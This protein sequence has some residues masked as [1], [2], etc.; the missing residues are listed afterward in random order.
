VTWQFLPGPRDTPSNA[1]GLLDTGFLLHEA[2]RRTVQDYWHIINT[3]QGGSFSPTN[4]T[5]ATQLD[6]LASFVNY[7]LPIPVP[8][9]TDPSLVAS[10]R[11]AFE[12]AGCEVCHAGPALTDSG[13]GNPTLDLAAPV[14]Q[15]WSPGDPPGVL[16]HDVGTCSTASYPD[17]A[18]TD[19]DSDARPACLFD[20]PALRGLADSAPYFHDGSAATLRDTLEMT[21]GKMGNIN[22]LS[23]DEEN[24]LIEYLRSL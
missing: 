18:G 8:P 7:A 23:A 9:Q 20:T 14:V 10:G 13:T 21:R 16:L 19:D 1:G 17:V 5:Q 2:G 6:A 12:K 24:A 4:A 22:V 11:A 3:E 15:S